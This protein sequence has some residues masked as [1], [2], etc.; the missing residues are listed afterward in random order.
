MDYVIESTGLCKSYG[1]V[2]ALRSVDLRVARGSAYALVGPNGAGKTTMVRILSGI[3]APT[4]GSARVLGRSVPS[5][6]EYVRQ[7]CGFQT[8]ASLYEKLSA[9]D[10]LA[11]WGR[12][13][14]LKEEDI[15][16]RVKEV[17]AIFNLEARSQDLVGSFSKGMKQKLSIARALIHEP[18]I[19]FLDEPTAGLD[20]EASWELLAYLKKYVAGR[21]TVFLCSHR[22]EEVESLCD[23]VAILDKGV[24]LAS[25][26]SEELITSI[27]PK[28]VHLVE[29]KEDNERYAKLL[30]Q[31]G[32]VSEAAISDGRL[33][34]TLNTREDISKVVSFLVSE[35]AS[36]LSVSDEKHSLR[37]IYFKYMPKK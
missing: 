20:P 7:R 21:R 8:D 5:E 23:H 31:S 24:L 1:S 34:I 9:W 26:S 13:Y 30:L 15:P 35:N 33:R 16:S 12:L 4:C 6:G 25:G 11:I 28:P 18:D 2:E 3:L 22:L 32:L 29:L 19:L 37:D 10:N 27:W 36:I 14:G 17:L